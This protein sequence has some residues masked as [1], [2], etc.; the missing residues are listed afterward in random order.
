MLNYGYT[1]LAGRIERALVF[2]SFDPAAGTLHVVMDGRASL[3]WDLIE[4]LRPALDEQLIGWIQT[5]RWRKRDFEVNDEGKVYLRQQLARMVIQKSWIP[6]AK[7]K[8]VI[9][10]YAGQLVGR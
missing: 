9:R 10:W 4:L 3:V 1:V 7:I 2:E 6:D 5:Q 8:Q